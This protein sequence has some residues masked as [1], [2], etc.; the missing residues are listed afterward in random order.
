M[1]ASNFHCG[2]KFGFYSKSKGEPLNGF[3]AQESANIICLLNRSLWVH[4]LLDTKESIVH[5]YRT[6][7]H[8][9]AKVSP[10]H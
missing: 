3:Q 7:Y 8:R 6:I 5:R 4:F 10:Y 9:L 2:M 1:Q